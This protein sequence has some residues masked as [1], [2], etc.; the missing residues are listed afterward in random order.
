MYYYLAMQQKGEKLIPICP[1]ELA[2]GN[3]SS[4]RKDIFGEEYVVTEYYHNN[5]QVVIKK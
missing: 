4:T 3:S 1:I 5:L 2:H